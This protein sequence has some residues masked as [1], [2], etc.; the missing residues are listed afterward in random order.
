MSQERICKHAC[1]KIAELVCKYMAD[2]IAPG[3]DGAGS[4]EDGD[5]VN[6]AESTDDDAEEDEED[7]EA[8]GTEVHAALNVSPLTLL[9][10]CSEISKC[11]NHFP[12]ASLAADF[13]LIANG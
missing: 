5:A 2:T 10:M 7:D 13:W 9:A 12:R 4:A 6:A 3:H 11:Q 1:Q 8:D